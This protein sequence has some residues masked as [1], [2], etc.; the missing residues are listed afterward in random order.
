MNCGFNKKVVTIALLIVVLSSCVIFA[1]AQ[2]DASSMRSS[3]ASQGTGSVAGPR[4]MGRVNMSAGGSSWTAGKSS[5]G[6]GSQRGGIWHVTPGGPVSGNASSATRSSGPTVGAS[7]SDS[8]IGSRSESAGSRPSS[9]TAIVSG[10]SSGQRSGAGAGRSGGVSNSQGTRRM[11]AGGRGGTMGG[12]KRTS[13]SGLGSG[14]KLQK[15]PMKS[16]ARSTLPHLP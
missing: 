1:K 2:Q 11:A 4:G 15:A 16:G 5:F 8:S 13:T 3:T 10:P 14:A 6:A 9:G 7:P 12:G